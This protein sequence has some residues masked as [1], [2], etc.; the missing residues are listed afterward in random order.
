VKDVLTT[1]E[2]S[3][4]CRVA[5]RTVAMWIDG[6]ELNGHRVGVCR[7]VYVPD[8]VQ[9]M[10]DRNMPREWW[11]SLVPKQSDKPQAAGVGS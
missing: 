1:T 6:G 5:P 9:F 3:R 4:I 8:L 11:E 7:R 10:K 2:I